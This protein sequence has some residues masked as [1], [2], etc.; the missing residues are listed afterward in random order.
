MPSGSVAAVL[1]EM[2]LFILTPTIDVALSNSQIAGQ[3][4]LII[5]GFKHSFLDMRKL[6][7][8]RET[9]IKPEE[10]IGLLARVVK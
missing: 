4:Y 7:V 5:K 6:W 3:L 1:Q 2:Y 8:K 10:R 9:D